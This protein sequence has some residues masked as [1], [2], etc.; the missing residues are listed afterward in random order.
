MSNNQKFY[1]PPIT[2]VEVYSNDLVIKRSR[3]MAHKHGKRE[4]V[5]ELSKASLKRLAFVASN[6]QVE[7]R[8]MLT[9][10]YPSIFPGS[11][12]EVKAHLGKLLHCLAVE[13]GDF[14]YLWFLEFQARGA[15]H[16]HLLTN[17][18]PWSRE[19]FNRERAWLSSVWYAIVDSGDLKHWYAGTRFEWLR[20]Q[21]GGKRYIISYVHKPRQ[22]VVPRGFWD[23][24]R[25]WGCSPNVRPLP[26]FSI[27]IKEKELRQVL[28]D[29]QYL[30]A[31][32]MPRVLYNTS[33]DFA[34]LLLKLKEFKDATE[35]IDREYWREINNAIQ[36][37]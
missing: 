10:T 31:G 2:A 7:F 23:V 25:F 29:W 17:V 12:K 21:E 24:G 27:P 13:W 22:K 36:A 4:Q 26:I 33:G 16:I 9:L 32:D 5:K 8:T 35:Q 6:T 28:E 3:K 37:S 1:F 34:P 11:G 15:P 18:M 19:Q 14:E 20:S 30:P